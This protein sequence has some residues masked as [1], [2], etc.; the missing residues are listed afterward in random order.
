MKTFSLFLF[1]ILAASSCVENDYPNSSNNDCYYNGTCGSNSGNQGGYGRPPYYNPS[2][3]NRY[4]YYDYRRDRRHY[5]NRYDNRYDH[6]RPHDN[7]RYND[8]YNNDRHDNGHRNDDRR[9]DN[10]HGNK[11]P[12]YDAPPQPK[13][14]RPQESNVVRP[15]CPAGTQFTGSTCRITDQRLRRP[16]GDGNINPCPSGQ[17]VSGDRCVGK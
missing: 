17:W 8:R 1:V 5:D 7:D 14:Q 3:N 9:D 6:R 12:R 4:D 13:P 15:H 10:Y 16:G 11:P 2:R